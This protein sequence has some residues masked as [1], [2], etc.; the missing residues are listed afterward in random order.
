LIPSVRRE[1]NDGIVAPAH[2]EWLREQL[3]EAVRDEATDRE[4]PTRIYISR[5][6]ARRRL[7]INEDTLEDALSEYGFETFCLCKL[8]QTEI[9]QLFAG[10]DIVVGPH[11]AGLTNIMY[12]T[13]ATVV[14]LRPDDS[15]S[16]VYY[17]LSE[18]YDLDY[19]YVCG[20][21][22]NEMNDFHVCP[23]IVV[24]SLEDI[25]ASR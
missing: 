10:A 20:E 15:Y 9:I 13:S 5:D 19:R 12:P 18:Q 6:D 2:T 25:L 21:I 4:F 11:G 17:V 24:G 7:V 23:D 3:L 22:Q 16:W 14:E 1:Y 8:T